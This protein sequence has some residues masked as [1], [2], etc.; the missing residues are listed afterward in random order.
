MPKLPIFY[1]I[2]LSSG[3]WFEIRLTALFLCTSL[4]LLLWIRGV[5]EF[6]I[7]RNKN[8][9]GKT[10]KWRVVTPSLEIFFGRLGSFLFMFAFC[11]SVISTTIYKDT[12]FK[13]ATYSPGWYVLHVASCGLFLHGKLRATR[14]LGNPTFGEVL[15]CLGTLCYFVLGI[16]WFYFS[17]PLPKVDNDGTTVWVTFFSADGKTFFHEAKVFLVIFNGVL[18]LLYSLEFAKQLRCQEQ[19]SARLH[20]IAQKHFRACV[21]MVGSSTVLPIVAV[22]LGKFVPKQLQSLFGIFGAMDGVINQFAMA[23]MNSPYSMRKCVAPCTEL[24]SSIST[25]CSPVLDHKTIR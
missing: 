15:C 1:L 22:I 2:P 20:R 12:L 16:V 3:M 4:S 8:K 17:L 10:L 19:R 9:V 21:L 7:L 14:F 13:P 18:S 23:W 5:V 24:R 6:F 11:A 25:Q